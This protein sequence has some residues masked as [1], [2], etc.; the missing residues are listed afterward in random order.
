M[1]HENE[2]SQN[3]ES[4]QTEPTTPPPLWDP[5][6][7]LEIHL[8]RL[9]YEGIFDLVGRI[10]GSQIA[11]DKDNNKT[12]LLSIMDRTSAELNGMK[13]ERDK[14]LSRI[15][16][17]EAEYPQFAF[18]PPPFSVLTWIQRYLQVFFSRGPLNATHLYLRLEAAV[19]CQRTTVDKFCLPGISPDHVDVS[20]PWSSFRLSLALIL[21]LAASP[22]DM[23][24]T[25]KIYTRSL[26]GVPVTLAIVRDTP[27]QSFRAAMKVAEA[28][29]C[30][31]QHLNVTKISA[32]TKA[33]MP[34]KITI[35]GVNFIDIGHLKK[36]TTVPGFDEQ[37][38]SFSRYFVVGAGPEGF[39]VWQAGGKGSYGFHEYINRGGDRIRDW[40]EAP[41]FVADFE[42]L[43]VEKVSLSP[44]QVERSNHDPGKLELK[45][46]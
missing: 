20:A 23:Y 42:R 45:D 14:Y 39:I 12:E 38:T 21:I 5:T 35:L 26:G 40:S 2:G 36:S 32:K 31:P 41:K 16:T 43:A 22:I 18:P 3:G 28:Q 15:A 19:R 27:S 8:N 17:L 37:Y 34:P 44:C 4:S 10:R 46:V 30:G 13:K 1:S 7:P 6:L 24:E 33:H 29:A 9:K 25:L 11:M